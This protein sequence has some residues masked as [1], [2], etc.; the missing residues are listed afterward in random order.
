VGGFNAENL[1]VT[2]S[3]D[4]SWIDVRT[5]RALKSLLRALDAQQTW[6][7]LEIFRDDWARCL[8]VFGTSDGVALDVA[9]SNGP[10]QLDKE[11]VEIRRTG[12]GGVNETGP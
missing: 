5:A 6:V 1:Q 11:V 8:A 9:D 7:E 2:R 12:I 10:H 3:A 4:L